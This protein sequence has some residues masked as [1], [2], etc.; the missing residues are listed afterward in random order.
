MLPIEPIKTTYF[1]I[2]AN[3]Q[4]AHQQKDSK[5]HPVHS[6]ETPRFEAIRQPNGEHSTNERLALRE[7]NPSRRTTCKVPRSTVIFGP[8]LNIRT[9]SKT[10]VPVVFAG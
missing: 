3:F 1:L 7:E 2:A 5:S 9:Q 6:F 4:E 8:S 10:M